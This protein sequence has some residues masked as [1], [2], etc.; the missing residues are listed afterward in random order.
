[1]EGFI[2]VLAVA[3]L[4]QHI[5]ATQYLYPSC[6]NSSRSNRTNQINFLVY[7]DQSSHSVK[8]PFQSWT[9]VQVNAQIAYILLNEIMHYSVEFVPV[10]TL[11]TGDAINLVSGCMQTSDCSCQPNNIA[12]P[13]VHV[14]LET[15][16]G[17]ITQAS[18]LPADVRPSLVSVLNYPGDDS[19]FLW[20]EII[21]AAWNSSQRLS[22]DYYRS[23]DAS[24]FEPHVFFDTWQK[25]LELLPS[26]VII[27]CSEMTDPESENYANTTQYTLVT[28][29]AEIMCYNDQVWFSPSCRDNTT[30]C[31]P[32]MVQ[33]FFDGLMQLSYFLNLPLA[34]VMVAKGDGD[35]DEYYH[36]AR[37]GRLLF[38]HYLPDDHLVDR[39]GRL[40]VLLNLPR[41][42]IAEQERG[43]YRTGDADQNLENYVWRKLPEIDPQVETRRGIRNVASGS[44]ARLNRGPSEATWMPRKARAREL[45][46]TVLQARSPR[47]RLPP[48]RIAA[49]LCTT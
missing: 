16:A 11:V 43:I 13:K 33:Y 44:C 14:T 3:Q 8:I 45:T 36:A 32:I 28:N 5:A 42:N 37:V 10:Y 15:W 17:G 21:E 7:P 46:Q 47:I 25:M 1:M 19:Y 31:V 48:M 18:C 40:P 34:I 22:L 30:K 23:Y 49:L 20:G 29:D 2:R 4:Y 12:D 26:E 38:G 6:F 9:S 24:V 39:F 35:Y 27:R 41:A